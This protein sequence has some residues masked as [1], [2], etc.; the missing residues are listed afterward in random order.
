MKFKLDFVTNSSSASFIIALDKLSQEQLILIYNHFSV[1]KLIKRKQIMSY[2]LSD[3]DEW[4][5]WEDDGKLNGATIM[6]NFDMYW[7]LQEIGI[8]EEVIEYERD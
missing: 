3:H 1:G 8:P 2:G 7:F 5:I 4:L 6:D